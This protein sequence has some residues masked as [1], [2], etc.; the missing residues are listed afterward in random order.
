MIPTN[1]VTTA[2]VKLLPASMNTTQAEVLI[3]AIGGQE[4][5]YTTRAQIGGPARSF[6]MF[7]PN[8]VDAL[9]ANSSTA[10]YMHQVCALVSVNCDELSIY[11]AL[12]D[13]SGDLL[14]CAMA[15]LLLWADPHPLP[16]L[17]DADD[18]WSCY[19][20]NWRPGKPRVWDWPANYQA[21]LAAF[22]V[23]P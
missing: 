15:R 13:A 9:L 7:E 23:P 12:G 19:C 20:R 16:D 10:E 17:N 6:W 3:G 8:G 1:T 18:A 14:A 2:L 11:A 22:G 4:S 21:S 5:S